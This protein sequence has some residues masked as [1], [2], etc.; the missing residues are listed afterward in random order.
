LRSS[1]RRKIADQ[2]IK[3][4]QISVPSSET[5]S[6]A[7]SAGSAPLPTL[8]SIRNA[9]L[10]ENALTARFTTTAGPDLRE[11]QGIVYVGAHPGEEERV[12]W[13][14]VEH[15]P[16]YD[17]RLYPTVYTLWNNPHLVPLLYTPEMVM[18]KL[19]GGADLMTPG[20][21]N[22]PP[23]PEKA[24]KDAV[25]AVA[26]LDKH[27]V[28]AFVGLCEIDISALGEVQ[29]TKGHAVRGLH[30]E[31][32][33]LWAWSSS[34]RPG[35]PSP[36]YIEGWE[37]EETDEVEEGIGELTLDENAD[38]AVEN[39]SGETPGE[40][41]SAVAE[42]PAEEVQEPSTKGMHFRRLQFGRCTC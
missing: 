2:I 6:D 18:R 17:K 34:S 38:D 29:G 10:P 27:T 3:D 30:W 42:E 15:G 9:L 26:S 22:E 7:P 20:L 19:H 13:F 35:R 41:A 5:T 23:F 28:P 24:V 32:D 14:K 8:A 37:D 39:N 16:G 31:G 40:E 11:V 21:A 36:E 12:L 33:E 4:Y 1:D 25:V